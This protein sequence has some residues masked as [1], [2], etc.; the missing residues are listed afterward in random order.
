MFGSKTM[1]VSEKCDPCLRLVLLQ[2]RADPANEA[3]AS[4][5]LQRRGVHQVRSDHS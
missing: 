1:S 5:V 4:E 3:C 2:P